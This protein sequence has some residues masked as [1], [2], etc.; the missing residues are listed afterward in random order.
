MASKPPENYPAEDPYPQFL[1]AK[2]VAAQMEW[3]HTLCH[4]FREQIQNAEKGLRRMKQEEVTRWVETFPG[5]VGEM[6]AQVTLAF[7]ALEEA[8]MR[9]GK[10]VQYSMEGKSIYDQA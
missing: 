6:Q 5:Q 4:Q 10:V 8:R 7:R 3:L 2:P 9:L 1:G